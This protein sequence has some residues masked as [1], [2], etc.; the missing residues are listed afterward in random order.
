MK[1]IS[2]A[3]M[4][5]AVMAILLGMSACGGKSTESPIESLAESLMPETNATTGPGAETPPSDNSPENGC[6]HEFET[7]EVS[8][9]ATCTKIGIKKS[10]CKKCHE[11]VTNTIPA[12][13][14][15]EVV[16]PAVP[17][18]CK[19]EGRTEGK[20]CSACNDVLIAQ[21]TVPATG[22][23]AIIEKEIPATC[24]SAGRTEGKHCATCEKILVKSIELPATGHNE[25]ID[26]AISATC[27]KAGKTEGK[28]CTTCLIVTVPQKII[29]ATGHVEMEDPGVAPTCTQTGLK[30][31]RHCATCQKILVAREI[32]PPLG[33]TEVVDSSSEPT[34]EKAGK[35][36]G[37]HCSVCLAVTVQPE[38][39]EALGHTV[40][41]DLAVAPTCT[42]T[43]LSAGKHCTT[44]EKILVAREEVPARGHFEEMVPA[45]PATCTEAGMKE[46]KQCAV[47][48]A[49]LEPA[50]AEAPKGHT[51]VAIPGT[52]ATCEEDGL[53]EGK[54]CAVC[55]LITVPQAPIPAAGHTP[56]E[57]AGVAATCQSTGL[58]AGSKC[59]VCDLA[60]TGQTVIPAGHYE[61]GKCELCGDYYLYGS[62]TFTNN[63]GN[64]TAQEMQWNVIYNYYK[65]GQ[66]YEGSTISVGMNTSYN[67]LNYILY[68][69][70]SPIH[71]SSKPNEWALDE[72]YI[73]FP[74]AQRVSE[75]QY[76]L[77]F[78]IT[79]K[80]KYQLDGVWFLCN[81]DV[82]SEMNL[83]INQ[84]INFTYYDTNG[85]ACSGSNILI[86]DDYAQTKI[87]SLYFNKTV[88]SLTT[89]SRQMPQTNC[90]IDFGDI[91]QEVSK[92]F[93]TAFVRFAY[94][95][96]DAH[97]ISGTWTVNE[98]PSLPSSV[99]TGLVSGTAHNAGGTSFDFYKITLV[100]SSGLVSPI[101]FYSGNNSFSGHGLV[102]V[103]ITP[104]FV[105]NATFY[106]TFT[107]NFTQTNLF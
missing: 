23:D 84:D 64:H 30:A 27:E 39:I 36:E 32:L 47:C 77:F 1:K 10:T 88:L 68:F 105:S 92:E 66:T 63:F 7:V 61:D 75:E 12:L 16:D 15:T 20:H 60:L 81:A 37:K 93:Y 87:K 5:L 28:H 78:R 98:T 35:T 24:T 97:V 102:C 90:F 49:V 40:V 19:T 59:A 107:Q 69:D 11:V 44:C 38:S 29:D 31:G 48:K 9:E 85:N 67:V 74:T 17:A 45:V 96:E 101:T 86:S 95:Y 58:K 6:Q 99:V 91:P 43:G 41:T 55:G 72:R 4:L 54:K 25:V 34:C 22:H 26:P 73:D 106:E 71:Y 46:W 76:E 80:G 89:S 21:L 94:D 8:V 100:K 83:S 103:E 62:Y 13:G 52:P 33:H 70:G 51:E 65:G 42:T 14:H 79:T 57:V 18:T 82:R 104:C 56:V 50:V 3:L 53:T 2:F